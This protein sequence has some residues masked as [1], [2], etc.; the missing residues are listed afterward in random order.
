M[1]EGQLWHIGVI[2][3]Q[4]D[5]QSVSFLVSLYGIRVNILPSTVY[6]HN[7]A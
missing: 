4:K 6:M 5:Q 3:F 7:L 2:L 1:I